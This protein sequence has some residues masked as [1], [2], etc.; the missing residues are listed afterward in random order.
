MNPAMPQDPLAQLKDIH[1]PDPVG[2]WPPAMGWW[3]LALF[4]VLA[5][6][7]IIAWLRHRHK[8]NAYRREAL[9]YLE[10]LQQRANE[11]DPITVATQVSGLLKRV[12]ITLFGRHQTA[13]LNG[14]DWL[15]FLDE[16]G[17]TDAFSQGPGKM[18]GDDIY[19]PNAQ[20]DLTSLFEL[21]KQWIEKQR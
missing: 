9:A 14:S 6:V 1:L 20:V 8:K 13:G 15:R 7:A 17:K 4:A 12:A 5:I 18:L 2:Q 3:L 19:K 10:A 16:K 21:S 11:R